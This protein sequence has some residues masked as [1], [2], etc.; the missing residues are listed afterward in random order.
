VYSVPTKA[1][2]RIDVSRK[3]ND[4]I[5]YRTCGFIARANVSSFNSGQKYRVGVILTPLNQ[6]K[7]YLIITDEELAL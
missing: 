2:N 1:I 5:D 4:G 3:M 7:G 6:K